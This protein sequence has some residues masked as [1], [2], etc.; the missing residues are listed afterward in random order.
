MTEL[1]ALNV[2]ITGDAADLRVALQS[3]E[4]GLENVANQAKTTQSQVARTSGGFTSLGGVLGKNAFAINNAANQFSD[5]AVQIGAG[6]PAS[7]ALSQQLPQITAFMGP[8]ANIIGVTAG[9]LIGMGGAFLSARQEGDDFGDSLSALDDIITSVDRATKILRTSTYD[10]AEQYGLLADRVRE[11]A[12]LELE[13]SQARATAA[14]E[15][16]AGAVSELVQNYARLASQASTSNAVLQK[17][18]REFD[19]TTDVAKQL[20]DA[21]VSL[22]NAPTAEEQAR[23]Y[24]D[25]GIIL[26]QN[27]VMLSQIPDELRE[28]IIAG[29]SLEQKMLDTAAAISTAAEAA[30][31]L[32][33]NLPSTAFSGDLS[34]LFDGDGNVLLPPPPSSGSVNTPAGGASV[35][36]LE[37]EL[38]ALQESLMTQ[39]ELELASYQRRLD[40]LKEFLAAGAIEADQYRQMEQALQAQHADAMAQIDAYRYGSTLDKTGAFLGDMASALSQGN[41]EML[42]ISKKFAAAEALVNAWQAYAQAL[43]DP[44]INTF[45]KIAAAAGVLAAGLGAVSSIQNAQPGGTTSGGSA[46]TAAPTAAAAPSTSSAVA[47]QLT[48]G[49]MFSRDQVVDLINAINEAVEDGAT[50]RLV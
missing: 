31:S 7:R 29:T 39:E 15:E 32:T 13:L 44:N 22:A 8:L 38:A 18:E 50:V 21:F 43:A 30:G 11:L 40:Q 42:E 25:I 4:D 17:I 33:A 37:A 49:D 1:A 16:Q 45:G 35:D 2:K 26:T 23:V 14:F 34:D 41:S 12:L 47:I 48:G 19:V 24:T 5:L 20:R 6:V 36:P 3:A 10:L 46:A 27:N 28:A 9:V